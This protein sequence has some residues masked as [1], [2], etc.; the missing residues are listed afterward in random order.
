[1]IEDKKKKNIF[2]RILLIIFIIFISLYF[3]DN[4]GYYNFN[5]KNK[6]LTEKKM[7]EFELDVKNG[8]KIDIKEYIKDDTNYKNMYSN[9]GYESSKLIDKTLNK[10]FINLGK[11]L[12]KL[13]Q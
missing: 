12:K 8:K 2:L 3:M 4:L 1:M 10:S 9:I 6:I 13:F 11:I 7:K 5:N